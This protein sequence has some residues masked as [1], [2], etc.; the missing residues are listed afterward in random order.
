MSMAVRL[1]VHIA[2]G[3]SR[4]VWECQLPPTF[5]LA[6]PRVE[7]VDQKSSWKENG[8]VATLHFSLRYFEIWVKYYYNIKHEWIKSNF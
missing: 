3:E 2:V 4:S 1:W 5:K 7:H 8:N 6:W